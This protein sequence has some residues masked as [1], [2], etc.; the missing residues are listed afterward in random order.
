MAACSA[1]PEYQRAYSWT[2]RQRQ[3]LFFGDIEKAVSGKGPTEG[4]FMAAP[5]VDLRGQKQIL[6][7]DEVRCR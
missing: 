2:S 3:D 4:H 6:G 5:V 7:T 1:F